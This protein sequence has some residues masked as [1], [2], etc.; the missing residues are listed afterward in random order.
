MAY[1][2]TIRVHDG[3]ASLCSSGW[4]AIDLDD[5]FGRDETSLGLGMIQLG[6][7]PDF[8]RYGISVR[9]SV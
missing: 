2:K 9:V 1:L 7:N 5:L 8:G 6:M 3:K 4:P